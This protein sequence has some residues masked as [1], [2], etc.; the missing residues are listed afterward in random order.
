MLPS[1]YVQGSLHDL[2]LGHV[3]FCRAFCRDNG[4]YQQFRLLPHILQPLTVEGSHVTH[5]NQNQWL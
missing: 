2:N 1:A 4:A 5:L 3:Q